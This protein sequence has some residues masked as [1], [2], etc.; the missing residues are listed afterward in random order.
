MITSK[1]ILV[2]PLD[3][4]LG[5]ISRCIPLIQELL[6][7]GHQVFTCGNKDSEL[8]FKEH[9]PHTKHIII[10]GY[11]ARYSKRNKQGLSMILQTPKFFKQITKERK[12]AEKLANQLNIDYILSDNR[13]GFRASRTTNIFLTHQIH[14]Q[15]PKLLTPIFLNIN[16]DS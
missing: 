6:N 4:G 11:N 1:N 12:T 9:F 2:A 16:R 14:I 8:I 13:F 3:W 10:D 15:G 7:R 5:H